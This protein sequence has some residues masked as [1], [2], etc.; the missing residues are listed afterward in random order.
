VANAANSA[1]RLNFSRF[2]IQ[3]TK[4]Q[5]MLSKSIDGRATMMEMGTDFDSLDVS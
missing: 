1:W 5:A 2:F 3:Q 4:P